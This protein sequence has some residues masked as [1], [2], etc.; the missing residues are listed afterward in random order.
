MIYYPFF[1]KYLEHMSKTVIIYCPDCRG[2]FSVPKSDIIEDDI[3]ECSLC[4]ASIHVLQE[5]PIKLQLLDQ[6]DF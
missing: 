6:D 3:I 1:D 4:G 5:N 2:K